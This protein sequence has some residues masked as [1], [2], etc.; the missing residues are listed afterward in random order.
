MGNDT[1]SS[2]TSDLI[3]L[4][5]RDLRAEFNENAQATSGRLSALETSVT[6][7]LG[8]GQPGRITNIERDI[9]ALQNWKQSLVGLWAGLCTV[10][11][12]IGS[13]GMWIIEH[14]HL[15]HLF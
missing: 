12:I 6:T 4:E 10:G 3:L 14:F 1:L 15:F 13:G 11:S 9:E 5:L 7:L 2:T 8:N